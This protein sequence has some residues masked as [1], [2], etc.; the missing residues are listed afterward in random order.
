MSIKNIFLLND[1]Q[2][3]PENKGSWSDGQD[4]MENETRFLGRWVKTI[5]ADYCWSLMKDA[6]HSWATKKREVSIWKHF[7]M[8]CFYTFRSNWCFIDSTVRF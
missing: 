3:F 6:L 4:F 2:R 5:T 1:I 7:N 8:S